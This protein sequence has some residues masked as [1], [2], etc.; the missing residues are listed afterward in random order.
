VN[1]SGPTEEGNLALA[2]V[3]CSLKKGAR[4]WVIDPDSEQPIRLFHPRLDVWSEHFRWQP[5]RIEGLTPCGRATIRALDL[6]RPLILAIR[7][8]ETF[9]GRYPPAL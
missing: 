9:W 5:P 4:Q 8:E 3:S 2:C 6:N 1:D 7:F